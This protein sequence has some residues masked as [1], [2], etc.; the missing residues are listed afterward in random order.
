MKRVSVETLDALQK[1][2]ADN[3]T[4]APQAL[5]LFTGSTDSDGH[6]WC[7]D[8]NV[9][10]PVIGKCLDAYAEEEPEEAAKTLFVTVFVG[11]RN[12]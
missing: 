5:I 9:S 7:P 3:K 11:Q 8:C 6:S 1:T 2:I 4:E 10:E 12:A